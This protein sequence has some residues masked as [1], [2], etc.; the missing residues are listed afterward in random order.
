V[1]SSDLVVQEL[2]QQDWINRVEARQHL[3]ER[4]PDDAIAFFS[5]EVH[6]HISGYVNKQNMRYCDLKLSML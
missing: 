6:F 3:I 1:C 5:D 2:T 4:L